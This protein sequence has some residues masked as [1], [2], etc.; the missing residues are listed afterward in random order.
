MEPNTEMNV[1]QQLRNLGPEEQEQRRL[2]IARNTEKKIATIARMTIM[3]DAAEQ[4]GVNVTEPRK[5]LAQI[6]PGMSH[7]YIASTLS[8]YTTDSKLKADLI[9]EHAAMLKS[10]ESIA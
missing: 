3:I 6:G 8:T 5:Q 2:M 1:L 4:R 7:E 9:A 10:L